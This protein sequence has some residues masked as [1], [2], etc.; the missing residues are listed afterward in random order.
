MAS[1]RMTKGEM[2]EGM[3]KEDLSGGEMNRSG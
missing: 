1:S 3:K 2:E